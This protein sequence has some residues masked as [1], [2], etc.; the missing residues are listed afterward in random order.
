MQ[1]KGLAL[2]PNINEFLDLLLNQMKE[3]VSGNS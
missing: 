1:G 3:M 2:L